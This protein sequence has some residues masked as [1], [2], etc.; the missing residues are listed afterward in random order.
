MM[1]LSAPKDLDRQEEIYDMSDV[2]KTLPPSKLAELLIKLVLP[3]VLTLEFLA[4]IAPAGVQGRRQA[5]FNNSDSCQYVS[6]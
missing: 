2:S 6:D 1:S 4:N 5:S 3:P